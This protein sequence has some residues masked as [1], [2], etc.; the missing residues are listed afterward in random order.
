MAG[1]SDT[2]DGTPAG[3]D[4]I[5]SRL[6][7]IAAELASE[8]RFKEPSAAERARARVTAVRPAAKE[9]APARFGRRRACARPR[10]CAVR[11]IPPVRPRP[12]AAAPA[13]ALGPAGGEPGGAGS[14]L[15]R[16]DDAQRGAL[17]HHDRHHRGPARRGV[18]RRAVPVPALRPRLPPAGHARPPDLGAQHHADASTPR[19][20]PPPSASTRPDPFAGTPAPRPTRTGQRHRHAG[21][22]R[23]SAS[24]P[25]P[26]SAAYTTTAQAANRRLPQSRRSWSAAG[27]PRSPA[28]W[29]PRSGRVPAR[30]RP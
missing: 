9:V 24:S 5:N 20:S 2:P 18:H 16:R 26:R 22:A 11:S 30:P 29:P 6:A 23:R 1:T 15:R 12:A 3:P 13:V 4:D 25:P 7:E 21:R 10:N 27:P 14:R 8:A 19:A 17:R 28:C